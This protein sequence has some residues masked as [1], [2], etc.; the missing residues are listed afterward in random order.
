[1]SVNLSPVAGVAGQLF[2]NNGNPLTGGKI[3]TYS[4]GT[5]TNQTTYT[6]S[7]GNVAQSNPIILD[8][9]GRVP[10]GEI[11]LTDGL[12]YKFVI[13]DSNDVLI[14]TYDNVVGINS[15]FVNFI[16]QQEIQTATAGQTVFTLTTTQYQPGTNSLMVFVDGVNQYGPGAQ[17]AYT[18]TNATTVTFVNGLH[19]GAKVKFTTSQINSSAATDASQVSYT[20]AGTG[21]VATNVQAK[22]RNFVSTSDFGAVGDGVTDD[23]VAVQ[24][25]VDY[26]IAN[27]LNLLVDGICLLTASVDIDRQVDGAAFDRYFIIS[28]VNGGGFV[29]STAIA[30]FSS[31]IP[32]TTAPVTQLTKF[33]N[34]VF[35]TTDNSLAAY[36][37]DGA[38]FLRVRFDDCSFQKIKLLVAPTY[39]QSIYLTNCNVRRFTGIFFDSQQ[40]TYDFKMV[41]CLVEAGVS[42]LRLINPVGCAVTASCIEGMSGY[43][44]TY[45]A[46]QG[47]SISGCYFEANGL[48]IDGTDGGTSASNSYGVQLTGNYFSNSTATYTVKWYAV[49]G[50]ISAGNWH[51]GNMHD[52]T[53]PVKEVVVYD[54][55][56]GSISNS[57][58]M[59]TITGGYTVDVP[60]TLS[61]CT[62]S[63]VGNFRCSVN[64]DTVTISTPI[65]TGTSNTTAATLATLPTYLRPTVQ[66]VLLARLSDN[67]ATVLGIL[68][69]DTSGVITLA[70]D[71]TGGA[72]TAS[73]SKGIQVNTLT[74]NLN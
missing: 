73:G 44:I 64:G 40:F 55:A 58:T 24:A 74:Y 41:N 29:V 46:A 3:Y 23:T 66:Q 59:L 35:S 8:A 9:A 13:T 4:A 65:V 43:A 31:S 12:L 63:P 17:Y 38:R 26:C 72:F 2:D 25:A 69:I 6:S 50:S 1:M 71:V 11:W 7:A 48:D 57:D 62:T 51:T 68:I 14:G 53:S 61:G 34:L 16:N 45:E 49:L 37:L 56:Q 54:V 70:A 28:S 10:A 20:P 36:V 30:M 52:F 47:L 22:L 33:E 21:A 67:S 27:D 15:N 39:T 5:T 60:L 19:V 32:F 18:E 42:C